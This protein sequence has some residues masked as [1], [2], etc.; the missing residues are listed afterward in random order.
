MLPIA[1]VRLNTPVRHL[2]RDF[3]YEVAQVDDR[4]AQPGARV[5]VRFAGRLMD[6]VILERSATATHD[7]PLTRLHAVPSPF[8]TFTPAVIGA[9]HEVAAA[10]LGTFGDVARSAAPPRQARVERERQPPDLW[11]TV[12]ASPVGASPVETA[13]AAAV[14]WPEPWPQLTAGPALL[15]RIAAGQSVGAAVT[16]PPGWPWAEVLAGLV[17]AAPNGG[18]LIVAP[19]ADDVGECSRSLVDVDQVCLTQALGP[20]A[21]YRAFLRIR[22]GE[23]SLVIGTRNAVFAPVANLRLIIVV[24]DSDDLHTSPRAPYWNTLAVARARARTSGCAL[25]LASRA[26]SVTAQWCVEYEGFGSVVAPRSVVRRRAPR[27]EFA[28]DPNTVARAGSAGRARIPPSAIQAVR[29]GLP[30]G[31]VLVSVPRRGYRPH[32]ACERCRAPARCPCGGGLSAADDASPPACRVCQRTADPWQ[33]A[34]CG[35]S[36]L[37]GLVIGAERTAEELTRAFPGQRV[38]LAELGSPIPA[39]T[40]QECVGC[41]IVATP[42]AEPILAGGYA[43]AVILDADITLSLPLL[44]AGETALRRWLGVAAMV[45]AGPVVV[46]GRHPSPEISALIRWDPVTWARNALTE[47]IA[48]HLPPASVTIGVRGTAADVADLLAEAGS[49]A[50]VRSHGPMPSGTQALGYLVVDHRSREQVFPVLRALLIARSAR[51]NPV[52]IRVDPPWL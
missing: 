17:R 42:G 36:R 22:N 31:P 47:R 5:R 35:H 14:Q 34:R 38:L 7:G 12:G 33:C 4:T 28:G 8:A 11:P 37:R 25:V 52:S 41:L 26:R 49:A 20:A 6:G 9:I 43:G 32:L 40:R 19:T 39:L 3:D 15:R 10:F 45:P 13:P 2:D 24:D 51:G 16:L 1:R 44:D 29:A 23:T 21:R 46:V 48:A 18:V 50:P 30:A 27:I